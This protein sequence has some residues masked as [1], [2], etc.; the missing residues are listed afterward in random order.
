MQIDKLTDKSDNF[1]FIAR[2]I[3]DF[4]EENSI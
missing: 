1:W 3:K 2:S 4:Y